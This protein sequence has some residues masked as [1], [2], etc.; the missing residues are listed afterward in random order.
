MSSNPTNRP[1]NTDPAANQEQDDIEAVDPRDLV[2][3]GGLTQN[4]REI[5]ENPAVTPERLDDPPS[6]LRADLLA[7]D[8]L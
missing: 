7:D 3:K 1:S 6:D 2:Y 4:R 5:I 8:E